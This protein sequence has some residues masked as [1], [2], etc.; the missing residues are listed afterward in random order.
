MEIITT[1]IISIQKHQWK[2][3]KLAEFPY[4]STNA[5]HYHCGNFHTATTMEIITIW[6]MSIH[7]YQW[8][9]LQQQQWKSVSL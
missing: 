5:K 9:S 3:L 1:W 2:S 8:K 6:I 7:E 4:S